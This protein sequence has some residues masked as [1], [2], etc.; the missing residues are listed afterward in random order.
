MEVARHDASAVIYIDDAAGEEEGVHQRDHAAVRSPHRRPGR[1]GEVD[2]QVTARHG[3][4]E[5]ATGRLV[6]RVSR[7]RW[8]GAVHIGGESCACL[9]FEQSARDP[10]TFG[11]VGALLILVAALASA[12]PAYRAMRADP[13]TVLR[14]E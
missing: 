3:A 5:R 6:T 11:V 1:A 12:I 14:S 7:G 13:N 2:A 10:L 9:L 8:N 4:V